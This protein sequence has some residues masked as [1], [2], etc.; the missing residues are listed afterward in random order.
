MKIISETIPLGQDELLCLAE[1][2]I[3]LQVCLVEI[4]EGV[5]E[6]DGK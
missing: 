2:E 1:D 6:G 3:K 5:R 4:D